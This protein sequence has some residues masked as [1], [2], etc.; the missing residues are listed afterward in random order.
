MAKGGLLREFAVAG[1]DGKFTWA[2]AEIDGLHAA[3]VEYL[4]KLSQENLDDQQSDQLHDFKVIV[5]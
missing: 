1:A 2:D 4:G 5:Q 3:I